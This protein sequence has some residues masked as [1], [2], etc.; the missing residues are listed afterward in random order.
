MPENLLK[1][2]LER[3]FSSSQL[4]KIENAHIGI[5]GAGGLGSNCAVNLVRSGF[6]RFCIA[7]YDLV[8]PS[9]LNRQFFFADQI[10]RP[11]V[12]ALVENLKRINPDIEVKMLNG[13]LTAENV[14]EFFGDCSIVVEA[15]DCA[16][17]KIM[18]IEKLSAS[19]KILIAASGLAGWGAADDIITRKLSDKFFLI[20][21]STSGIES[22]L[23]PCAPRVNVASAKQADIVLSHIL[24]GK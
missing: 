3:Y 16:A 18:L 12:E 23:P 20:G 17:A 10:G 24:E 4:E 2:G 9:N 7:D 1:K 22:G 6:K 15:F 14:E 13:R 11:K 5:A 8:E 19:G 21:D